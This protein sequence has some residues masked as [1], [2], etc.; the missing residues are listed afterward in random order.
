[1]TGWLIAAGAVAALGAWLRWA[2]APV[3]FAYQA[4]RQAERIIARHHHCVPQ[5]DFL[6]VTRALNDALITMEDNG[7]RKPRARP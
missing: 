3:L 2:V 6:L 7:I 4:G 1:M 5:N